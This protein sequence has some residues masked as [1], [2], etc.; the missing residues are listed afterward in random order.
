M[1]RIHLD[2][3]TRCELDLLKV[4]LVNYVNHPSFEVLL[5]AYAVNNGEV[6]QARGLDPTLKQIVEWDECH[7][8]AFNAPFERAVLSRVGLPTPL[9]KWRCTMAHS[10]ARGFSGTLGQVCE[11]VGIPEE[12][13]KMAEGRALINKFCKPRRPSKSNPDLFW[14]K[15]TAPEKWEQFE[16]YNRVDVLAERDVYLMLEPYTWTPEEQEI[17]EFDQE[18]NLTGLP[19]DMDL[20][21][22]AM[23]YAKEEEHRIT[24][25]VVALTGGIAPSQVKEL[26]QWVRDRG[27][28][29]ASL[30][31]DT[32]RAILRE[33]A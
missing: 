30:E 28:P 16:L 3:E 31:A 19:M 21:H 32:I 33:V 6:K 27:Y 1:N 20:V 13:R 25:E 12:H 18:V 17:W 22:N 9:S 11:Q 23:E 29:A 8:H 7:I 14:T 15:E 2:F 5:T 4:G 24:Q 26:L 10:Y